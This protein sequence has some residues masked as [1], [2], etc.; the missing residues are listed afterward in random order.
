VPVD[1][2]TDVRATREKC[3]SAGEAIAAKAMTQ[4]MFGGAPCADYTCIPGDGTINPF[5]YQNMKWILADNEDQTCN[6]VCGIKSLDC[7]SQAFNQHP[8]I[9]DLADGLSLP[10]KTFENVA[11]LHPTKLF[12]GLPLIGN[13]GKCMGGNTGMCTDTSGGRQICPCN[14]I[15]S[16][17]DGSALSDAYPCMCGGLDHWCNA[18]EICNYSKDTCTTACAVDD[19]TGLLSQTFPCA[20]S[21]NTCNQGELCLPS[22][23]TCEPKFTWSKTSVWKKKECSHDFEVGHPCSHNQPCSY[24]KCLEHCEENDACNFFWQS[25]HGT[26]RLFSSC[27]QKKKTTVPGTIAKKT[28]YGARLLEASDIEL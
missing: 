15:C 24:N 6:E 19:G 3:T 10:C 5:E 20:C 12:V 17:K 18:D 25:K 27:S 21:T 13:D 9:E 14:N 4:A 22:S 16:V 26:C 11:F 7:V 28:T 2:V 1:C 23:N 8:K